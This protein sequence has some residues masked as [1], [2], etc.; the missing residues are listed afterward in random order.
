MKRITFLVSFFL[1]I[2]WSSSAFAAPQTISVKIA[3]FPVTLNGVPVGNSYLDWFSEFNDYGWKMYSQYPLLVYKDITYFPMTWYY[4]NLLNLSTSWSQETGL[5]IG[6][7]D[8]GQWKDFR[9]DSRNN[10]NNSNQTA[11]IVNSKVTVNGKPIDNSKEP[12]PL[13]LFRDVTYFPLTWRF[14]VTEFGWRYSYTNAD[15]LIIDADNAVFYNKYVFD[16]P[17]NSLRLD[18]VF[19]DTYIKEDLKIWIE[20]RAENHVMQCGKMFISQNGKVAQVGHNELDR[21]GT[22]DPNEEIG[23]FRV[24]GDWVYTWYSDYRQD[25]ISKRTFVPARVNI[26][27]KAFEIIN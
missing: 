8:P 1:V 4:G 22:Q 26:M 2:T 13:L 9:Y 27:T 25:D 15:G 14:A 6:Q 17:H 3:N 24:E 11:A 12:Y 10:K 19:Y 5:V 20:Y 7:G 21:F 23:R 18:Y 16:N